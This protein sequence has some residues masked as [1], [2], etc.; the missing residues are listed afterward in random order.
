[1]NTDRY[2]V[3]SAQDAQKQGVRD[4]P[5]FSDWDCV[6]VLVKRGDDGSFTY[7]ADDMME[8]E[9]A[10]LVRDLSWVPVLLNELAAELDEAK[11]S[12]TS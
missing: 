9:D 3:M 12:K 10:L 7:V 1:M 11:A 5:E 4:M 6:W 8:P 2:Q